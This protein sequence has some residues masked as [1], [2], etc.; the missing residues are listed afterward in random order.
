MPSRGSPALEFSYVNGLLWSPR[1]H[2]VNFMTITG[3]EGEP[4]GFGPGR[5]RQMVEVPVAE[6]DGQLEAGRPR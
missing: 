3:P 2:F 6:R 4:D 1:S 5:D